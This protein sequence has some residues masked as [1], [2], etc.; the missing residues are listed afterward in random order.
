M[1]AHRY[2]S[3]TSGIECTANEEDTTVDASRNEVDKEMEK[4]IE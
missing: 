1:T 4:H 2:G 3:C